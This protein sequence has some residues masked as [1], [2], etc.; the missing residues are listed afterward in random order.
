M[1][2]QK[3]TLHNFGLYRGRQEIDLAPPSQD[4]PVVLFGGLNGG[5]KTTFL[6]ALLLALYGKNAKVSNRTATEAYETYLLKSISRDVAP[7]EGAAVELT[8]VHFVDGKAEEVRISRCWRATKKSV[9]ESV[10]V[11]RDGQ[12]DPFYAEHWDEYVE[13]LIPSR[14][15]RLFFFD[16]EKIESLAD[17]NSAADFIRTGVHDL[18]GLDLVSTLVTDLKVLERKIDTSSLP[19]EA[20]VALEQQ[21]ALLEETE[22]KRSTLVQQAGTL[23]NKIDRLKELESNLRGQYRQ[24]GGDLFD[25][26]DTLQRNLEKAEIEH[27]HIEDAMREEA[28]GSA[29]LLLMRDLLCDVSDRAQLEKCS[30]QAS[31]VFD[32]VKLRDSTIVSQLSELGVDD[33]TCDKLLNLL[34][35]DHDVLRAAGTLEHNLGLADLEL[36]LTSLDQLDAVET[37]IRVLLGRYAYSEEAV[38]RAQR[39]LSAIP[40]P[41][42]L[43]GISRQLAQ[44]EAELIRTEHE[45][46]LLHN[47]IDVC[48]VQHEKQRSTLTKLRQDNVNA[49]F[50]DE[51]AALTLEAGRRCRTYLV[52]FRERLARRNLKKI[53]HLM[54]ESFG[55]LMR[56]QSL[57]ESIEIDP[58]D[59]SLRLLDRHGKPIDSERLSAGERQLLSISILWSLSRASGRPIP[60]VIDTPLGRLDG[61]HRR[62]LVERYFPFAAHQV[63][64]LSTDEEV[65]GELYETIKPWLGR[66]YMLRYQEESCTSLIGDGY[67]FRG[68]A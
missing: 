46:E 47:E 34:E 19:P 16:G 56:K 67:D 14:L 55:Q 41:E 36:E 39:Q 22:V 31:L 21:E 10:E 38:S 27:F 40:D 35:Q 3:L 23:Q 15:A 62:H 33:E 50:Q 68:A 12:L 65:A 52:D 32:H 37:R 25:K 13:E 24:L 63:I 43:E 4:K 30:M 20:I 58:A 17:P 7:S 28:A 44:T 18:L 51:R 6:N 9:S 8:F 49:A 53:S 59:Y 48:S 54:L 2:F 45:Q 11:C 26:R 42:G 61:G 64:L 29:P 57:I 66:E 5:G 1:I 60:L